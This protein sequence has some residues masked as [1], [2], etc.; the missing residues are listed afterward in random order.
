MKPR[1]TDVAMRDRK[2][3][4]A[5]A[6]KPRR[7]DSGRGSIS[8]STEL[9][10]RAASECSL[11][12]GIKPMRMSADMVEY[13]VGLFQFPGSAIIAWLNGRIKGCKMTFLRSR[14]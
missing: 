11:F 4:A 8:S 6:I 13:L 9:V 2:A 12:L 10:N 5:I 7:C 14:I 3:I 1:S